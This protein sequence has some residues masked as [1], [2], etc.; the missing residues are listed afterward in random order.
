[1]IKSIRRIATLL[2]LGLLFNSVAQGQDLFNGTEPISFTFMQNVQATQNIGGYPILNLGNE[3]AL[4]HLGTTFSTGTASGIP[5]G[6]AYLADVRGGKFFGAVTI[7]ANLSIFGNARD[8]TDEPCKS[9]NYLWKKS[10]G[11]PFRNINCVSINY[12]V[13]YFVSPTGAFQ[14]YLILFRDKGI[15]L[16]PTIVRTIFTRFSDRGR[17][18]IYE[19]DINPEV[20]GIERDTE[21]IWGSNSW[22]KTFIQKDVKKVEFVSN[23]SKWAEEVQSRMDKAFDKESDA[24]ARMPEFSSYFKKTPLPKPTNSSKKG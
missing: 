22:H 14:Q 15:E 9:E 5:L 13:R 1:M 20:F 21:S 12:I 16:P 4:I 19:V 17:R 8:W 6:N 2:L 24:F 7:R 3:L 18:L 10:T 23:L 11:G